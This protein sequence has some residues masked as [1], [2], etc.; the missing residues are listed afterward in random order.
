MN[1][2]LEVNNHMNENPSYPG[3]W[4][5]QF[6]NDKKE[7]YNWTNMDDMIIMIGKTFRNTD[8]VWCQE[9]IIGYSYCESN[10]NNIL[11]KARCVY[12]ENT[13]KLN[14]WKRFLSQMLIYRYG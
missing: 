13:D 11:S 5:L 2:L 9:N 1:L 4:F 8:E 6:Y 7:L 3:D 12:D 10:K 14:F